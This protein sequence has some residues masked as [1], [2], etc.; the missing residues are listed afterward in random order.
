VLNQVGLPK[1]KEIKP[2]EFAESVGAEAIVT[3]P[4]EPGAFSAASIN[5]KM[6]AAVAGKSGAS[7]GIAELARVLVGQS[8]RAKRKL[9]WA[10]LFKRGPGS[11]QL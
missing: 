6:I 9:R 7:R 3:I 5:G 4:F 2:K 11:K 1:R 10:D 8:D